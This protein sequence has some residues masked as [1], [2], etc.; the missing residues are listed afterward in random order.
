MAV[1]QAKKRHMKGKKIFWK[2]ETLKEV[3]HP[4][5]YSSIGFSFVTRFFT[6]YFIFQRLPM[7]WEM[8]NK[9][10]K[11]RLSINSR[12]RQS[13]KESKSLASATKQSVVSY[14]SYR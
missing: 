8:G 10:I 14:G 2:M 12:S 6:S 4:T 13:D 1:E 5:F 11:R 7:H 3:S 9:N